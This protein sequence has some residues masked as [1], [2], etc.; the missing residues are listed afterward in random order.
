MSIEDSFARIAT[1]LE[2]IAGRAQHEHTFSLQPDVA[3]KVQD[4][5]VQVNALDAP[6]VAEAEAPKRGRGRPRKED[7]A[8]AAVATPQASASSTT[9]PIATAAPT[10]GA[11]AEPAV[12]YDDV[13]PLILRIAAEH[14]R[15]KVLE[16]LKGFGVPHGKDLN[17]EQYP[18]VVKAA[19]ELLEPEELA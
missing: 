12:T 6:E 17:P 14:G 11:A 19:L 8:P 15:P 9:E 2:I 16:F 10:A 7:S 3:A 13:Q 4:L 18:A 5:A 1:A